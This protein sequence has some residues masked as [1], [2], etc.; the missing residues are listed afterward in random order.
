MTVHMTVHIC[1]E[2]KEYRYYVSK[3]VRSTW[4]TLQ[5]YLLARDYILPRITLILKDTSMTIYFT[6]ASFRLFFFFSMIV[7]MRL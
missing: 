6:K 7:S 3:D 1:K 4:S 5:H 2:C